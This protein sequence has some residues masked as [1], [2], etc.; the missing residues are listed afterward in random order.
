MLA[1]T[2]NITVYFPN[3]IFVIILNTYASNDVR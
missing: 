2:L 1:N 3:D